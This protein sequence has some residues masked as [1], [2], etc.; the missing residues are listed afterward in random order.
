VIKIISREQLG[1]KLG[2]AAK[3]D[4]GQSDWNMS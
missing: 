1:K 4:L 3:K 2:K